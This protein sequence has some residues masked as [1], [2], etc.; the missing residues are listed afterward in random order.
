MNEQKIKPYKCKECPKT[1]LNNRDFTNHTPAKH[2]N[3]EF[4]ECDVCD[5]RFLMPNRTL[6]TPVASTYYKCQSSQM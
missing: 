3:D 1:Y 2:K 4:L 6:K 5:K